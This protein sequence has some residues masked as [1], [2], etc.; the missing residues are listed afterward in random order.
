M[1]TTIFIKSKNLD[2]VYK[3]SE[4]YEFIIAVSLCQILRFFL[5]IRLLSQCK[6]WYFN[7]RLISFIFNTFR[8]DIDQT[9]TEVNNTDYVILHFKNF[10]IV[11]KINEKIAIIWM[12]IKPY[13]NSLYIIK[14]AKIGLLSTLSSK[15]FFIGNNFKKI[16]FC[17]FIY[18]NFLHIIV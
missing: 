10:Y 2:H 1:K 4:H 15:Y 17:F 12:M 16:N 7:R 14:K 13:F 6:I 11:S 18:T 9:G 5:F 3:I 8:Q